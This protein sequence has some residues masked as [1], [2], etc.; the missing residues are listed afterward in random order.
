MITEYLF[1]SIKVECTKIQINLESKGSDSVSLNS[2]PSVRYLILVVFRSK[3]SSNRTEYP[4]SCPRGIFISSAT[5]DAIE[6]AAIRRGFQY[7]SLSIGF[8]GIINT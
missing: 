6:V 8:V 2:I 7:S 1:R 3:Q 5:L 4:T